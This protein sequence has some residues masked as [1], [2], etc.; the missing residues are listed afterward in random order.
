M[1]Y[2]K[3]IQDDVISANI[4]AYGQAKLMAAAGQS[5]GI[6]DRYTIPN[7]HIQAWGSW[8]NNADATDNIINGLQKLD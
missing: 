5:I 7:E 1:P 3:N 2:L 8:Q 4:Q 6:Y